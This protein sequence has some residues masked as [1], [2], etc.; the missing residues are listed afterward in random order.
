MASHRLPKPWP[1]PR[2]PW[3]LLQ[4][5]GM[6]VAGLGFPL[7]HQL[8]LHEHR[9][10]PGAS[11]RPRSGLGASC[12]LQA[13]KTLFTALEVP[14]GALACADPSRP[15]TSRRILNPDTRPWPPSPGPPTGTAAGPG[16]PA[17]EE[18]GNTD[19]GAP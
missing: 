19:E 8:H 3:R 16:P 1:P 11:S 9:L 15:E 5:S 6:P 14:H 13:F 2:A 18:P 10:H 7:A 4:A 12:G 17:E